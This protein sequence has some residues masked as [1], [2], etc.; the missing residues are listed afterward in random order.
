LALRVIAGEIVNRP[1]NGNVVAYWNKYGNEVEEVEKAIEEAKTQQVA[2]QTL[3]DRYLVEE[4]VENNQC[5]LRQ[6][7]LIKECVAG[8]FEANGL[9]KWKNHIQ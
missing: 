8:T 3:R 2:L 6:H 9:I 1:F 5:I 7:N 4:L